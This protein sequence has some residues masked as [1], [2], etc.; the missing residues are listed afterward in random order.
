[1]PLVWLSR[2]A[3]HSHVERVYGPDLLLEM[4]KRSAVT[5]HRHFF[6]GG[7]P[8][9]ADELASR[10]QSRFPG[11]QVAGTY[12]PP[13][14]RAKEPEMETTIRTMNESG[15]DIIWIGLGTP[16]QDWWA[17]NHRPF[18]DAPVLIGVG[19]AFDFHT[20]RVRQAPARIQRSGLEWL[21][22]LVQDPG[23]LWKRY[24]V[25]NSLFVLKVI[26]AKLRERRSRMRNDTPCDR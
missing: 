26:R 23:R 22:R 4:A 13:V 6:Y 10:L 12:S 21:F 11:L 9:V 18:L 1:M 3:G 14:M 5:G 7:A 19:A 8:A 17:A 2:W 24:L 15:A 16:K 25:Y 20:G